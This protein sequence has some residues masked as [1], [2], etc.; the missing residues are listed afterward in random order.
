[1]ATFNELFPEA[2]AFSASLGRFE[3]VLADAA[4]PSGKTTFSAPGAPPRPGLV[5]KDA[6][7]RWINPHTGEEVNAVGGTHSNTGHPAH[8]SGYQTAMNQKYAPKGMSPDHPDWGHFANGFHKGENER[9]KRTQAAGGYVGEKRN[10]VSS[11]RPKDAPDFDSKELAATKAVAAK[12]DYNHDGEDGGYSHETHENAGHYL[13][14]HTEGEWGHVAPGG[15]ETTGKG[16]AS[17]AKHLES[18]HKSTKSQ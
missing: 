13:D 9:H 6:T 7:K 4:T 12:H 16:A 10:A 15:K 11:V 18:V 1:M 5:W 14:L 8:V 3:Q 2:A 17:L